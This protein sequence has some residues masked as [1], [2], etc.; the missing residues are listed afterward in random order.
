MD[1]ITKEFCKEVKA[2]PQILEAWTKG[3][4]CISEVVQIIAKQAEAT[5][6]SDFITEQRAELAKRVYNLDIYEMR[7]NDTTPADIAESIRTNPEETIKY[8]LDYI[9][10]LQA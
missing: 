5:H 10:E 1:A 9:D 7:N 6:E 2:N 8:L 4:L 3:L